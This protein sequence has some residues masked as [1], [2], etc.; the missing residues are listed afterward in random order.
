MDVESLAEKHNALVEY[1][2]LQERKHTN[3]L[4]DLRQQVADLH[5]RLDQ[6]AQRLDETA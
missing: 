1:L 5:D 2:R 4:H 6:L 3:E